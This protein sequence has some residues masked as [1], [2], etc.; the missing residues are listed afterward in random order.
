MAVFARWR[1]ASVL[2]SGS[3]TAVSPREITS[4]E[5][6]GR[7]SRESRALLGSEA[8]CHAQVASLGMNIGIARNLNVV[9]A[10]CQQEPAKQNRNREKRWFSVCHLAVRHE[11]VLQADTI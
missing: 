6:T 10:T 3:R 8:G 2:A 4:R 7:E 1:T 9:V 11:R 5:T